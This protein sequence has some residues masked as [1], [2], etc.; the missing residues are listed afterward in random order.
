MT[1]SSFSENTTIFNP[2]ITMNTRAN[3]DTT[4]FIS[5]SIDI[6]KLCQ[7][8]TTSQ[9]LV[10]ILIETSLIIP[11]ESIFTGAENVCDIYQNQVSKM[12]T[13]RML[14]VERFMKEIVIRIL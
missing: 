4:T 7:T 3:H 12:I 2:I 11:A 14:S 6:P 5:A 9:S 1:R 10:S 13:M 8:L